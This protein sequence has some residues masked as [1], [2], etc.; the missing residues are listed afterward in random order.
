M[1][2]SNRYYSLTDSDVEV[3]QADGRRSRWMCIPTSDNSKNSVLF[4]H[5]SDIIYDIRAH[6]HLKAFKD[7]HIVHLNWFKELSKE[8]EG[9]TRKMANG[10]KKTI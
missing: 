3:E 10:K 1:I 9:L 4:H 6:S 8:Q 7:V 5:S 2:K